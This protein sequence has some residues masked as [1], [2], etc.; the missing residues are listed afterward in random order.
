MAP[1]LYAQRLAYSTFDDP[2]YPTLPHPAVAVF[3]F[4]L[5]AEFF[6]VSFHVV[7]W[8]GTGW[9]TRHTRTR[10]DV[11]GSDRWDG[12]LMYGMG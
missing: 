8:A 3:R 10:R 2:F 1:K 7:R 11:M 5:P 6:D 9:D 12:T 4:L